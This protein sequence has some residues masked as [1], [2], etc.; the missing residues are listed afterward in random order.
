MRPYEVQRARPAGHGE[1]APEGE[2]LRNVGRN[3]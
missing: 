2:D 3:G 1:E